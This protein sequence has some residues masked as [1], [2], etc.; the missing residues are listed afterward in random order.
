MNS[1]LLILPVFALISPFLLWPIE[2]IFP[3]P[4]II[5]E[6]L[7]ACFIPFLLTCN[8][9]KI[10][11]WVAL[12]FGILF[13]LSESV[14]YVFNIIKTGSFEIFILRLVL[15][16][17]LHSSTLIIMLLFT[18]FTKKLFPL[19]LVLGILIHYIYNSLHLPL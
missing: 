2:F 12:S 11:L 5:E 3:F 6:L 1:S 9:R 10:Q 8:D 14:L 16:S 15:T 19:S 13:A 4:Y 7:K 18:S 17:L